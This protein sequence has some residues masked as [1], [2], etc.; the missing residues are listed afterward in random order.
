MLQPLLEMSKYINEPEHME[1]ADNML[2]SLIDNYTTRN[3][4][5]SNGLL[6][7]AMYNRPKG[8][9]SE[10]NIWGD[11][12]YMEALTRKLNPDSICTFL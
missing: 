10:C 3:L 8:H 2:E 5:Y 12:F 11:Y 4:P 1:M 7:D 9:N 6:T